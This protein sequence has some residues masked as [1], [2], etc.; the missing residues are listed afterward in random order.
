[1]GGLSKMKGWFCFFLLVGGCAQPTSLHPT[2]AGGTNGGHRDGGL[3]FDDGGGPQYLNDLAQGTQPDLATP[4]TEDLATPAAADLAVPVGA[5]LAL[6]PAAD[7]A[8]IPD[9]AHA[10]VENCFNDI[11]DDGNGKI[12]DGCPDT[13]SVG[14]DVPLT[15]F[16]GPGGTAVSAHCPAG[17][18]ATGL[19]IRLDQNS[20]EIAGVGLYCATLML[21]RGA[22]SYSVTVSSSGTV[23]SEFFG[24]GWTYYNGVFCDSTQFQVVWY[25][26]MNTSESG[27]YPYVHGLGMQCGLGALALSPTNQLSITFSPVGSQLGYDYAWGVEHP[28]ACGP[29][30]AVVGYNGRDG[31]WLDQ[32]QPVCA[33]IVV[34]YKP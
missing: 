9:M 13:L 19:R 11:D 25:S 34:N 10:T 26:L 15:A 17:Q 27:T 23:A 1:M 5:D 8:T 16:G 2:D 33:P 31:A 30:Q 29:S 7:L 6:P 32:I 18:V 4:T 14:A 20:Q 12:N 28:Q 22:S 24:G 3:M 21:M